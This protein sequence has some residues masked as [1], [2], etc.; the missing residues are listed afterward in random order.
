[1]FL[2]KGR[3]LQLP[4]RRR[5]DTTKIALTMMSASVVGKL[6]TMIGWTAS[7]LHVVDKQLLAVLGKRDGRDIWCRPN[8]WQAFYRS[9]VLRFG[10]FLYNNIDT[11]TYRTIRI[12]AKSLPIMIQQFQ[13]ITGSSL[14]FVSKRHSLVN[15]HCTLTLHIIFHFFYY[16]L[17]LQSSCQT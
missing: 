17:R 1:M 11:A 8:I 16:V 4:V 12:V 2:T 6:A 9:H 13:C 15:P 7:R 10:R 5:R 14:N 3:V